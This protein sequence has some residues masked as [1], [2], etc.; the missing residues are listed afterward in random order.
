MKR[1]LPLAS[2]VAFAA[3]GLPALAADPA[4]DAVA[5]TIGRPGTEMPGGVYRVGIA[6]SDLTVMLDGVQLKP[7]LALG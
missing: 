5:K 4:W 7:A 2:F 6:R 3:G 1:L